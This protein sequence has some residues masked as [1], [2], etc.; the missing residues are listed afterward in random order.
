MSVRE[1][2]T[3]EAEITSNTAALNSLVSA[4]L[5][6]EGEIHEG[7][8]IA[9]QFSLLKPDV[10]ISNRRDIE[11]LSLNRHSVTFWLELNGL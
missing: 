3:F 6:T 10:S 7:A 9:Y 8:V 2:L 11:D 5:N 1:G 4:M